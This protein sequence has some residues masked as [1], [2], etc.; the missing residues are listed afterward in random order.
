MAA[1]LVHVVDVHV[2]LAVHHDE[3]LLLARDARAQQVVGELA[4]RRR[5]GV[6]PRVDVLDARA[7]GL[8]EP[9]EHLL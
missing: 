3:L 9:V 7:V 5:A 4:E 8:L 1:V 2:L 6:E